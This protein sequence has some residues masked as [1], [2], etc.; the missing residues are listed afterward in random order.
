MII[1]DIMIKVVITL[2]NNATL[3]QAIDLVKQKKIR[4]IPIV[5]DAQQLIGLLC[6]V[7]IRSAT[8][9]IYHL[10]EYK[11]DLLK[12]V[13]AI[14]ITDVYTAHPLDFVEEIA[15]V[16]YEQ[17]ISC[18]PV[19]KEN[20]LVGIVT[21]TDL[22]HTYVELTGAN[23]PASQIEVKV[24]NTPGTLSEIAEVIKGQ[25]SNVNSIFIYPYNEDPAF[26]VLVLRIQTMNPLKIVQGLKSAGYEVLWPNIPENNL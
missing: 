12:P 4:H 9:S 15:F 10:D 11:E 22:L 13:S 23:Q 18:M 6:D 8:P 16:F 2:Q 5:D 19:I 25:N 17:K 7:D 14:M 24:T 20:K 26:K 3:Q 1:E 21:E